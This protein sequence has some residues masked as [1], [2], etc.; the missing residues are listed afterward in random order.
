MSGARTLLV[1]PVL[2]LASCAKPPPAECPCKHAPQGETPEATASS[3]GAQLGTHEGATDAHHHHHGGADDTKAAPTGA[4]P[5]PKVVT[6][7]GLP[8]FE[9]S[10]NTLV[11]LATPSLGASEVEV[12]RSSIAIGSRTPLHTHASEE[13]FIVLSGSGVVHVGDRAVPFAAPATVIAP[14]GIPHWV[15]NTGTVPTDQLVVVRTGSE[16]TSADGR[17]MALPWRR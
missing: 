4:T 11:G 9:N 2:L 6:H 3:E 14:A 16:I 12:W 7:T 13:V 5:E 1:I 8:S 10:G 17:V 15:E